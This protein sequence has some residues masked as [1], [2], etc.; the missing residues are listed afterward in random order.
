VTGFSQGIHRLCPQRTT[1]AERGNATLDYSHDH[2][3]NCIPSALGTSL[4]AH[5]CRHIAVGTS[6]SAHRYRH[7][8]IGSKSEQP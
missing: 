6:L 3:G 4:S 2:D 8:A 5:R 1:R 7:I